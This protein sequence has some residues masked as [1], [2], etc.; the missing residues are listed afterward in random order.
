MPKGVR[1]DEAL[2]R[3]HVLEA[4]GHTVTG[5]AAFVR[6]WSA[7]PGLARLPG[8]TPCLE[9]GYR[10]FLRLRPLLTVHGRKALCR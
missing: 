1:R 8:V 3:F 2:R 7:Y 4:D 9:F 6:L 10:L 5:A